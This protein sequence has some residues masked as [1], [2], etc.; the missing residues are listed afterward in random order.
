MGHDRIL[1]TQTAKVRHMTP[2]I[3]AASN[4]KAAGAAS[5]LIGTLNLYLW[6]LHEAGAWVFENINFIS[7][8][9]GI[10]I[11]IAIFCMQRRKLKCELEIAN[12]EHAAKMRPFKRRATD[13]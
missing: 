13:R 12:E 5:G 2:L 4:P 1:T 11:S 9:V 7:G 3:N 8:V 10:S 6:R